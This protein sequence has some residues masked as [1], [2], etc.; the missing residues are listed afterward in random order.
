[1]MLVLK[2]IEPNAAVSI[3]IVCNCL[4][5]LYLMYNAIQP[6]GCNVLLK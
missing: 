5:L 4:L 2:P 6:F 3:F 1:M